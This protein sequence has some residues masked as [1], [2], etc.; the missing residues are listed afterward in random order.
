MSLL[1]R[2]GFGQNR[3]QE[4]IRAEQVTALQAAL[5]K[6]RDVALRG[7]RMQRGLA[8][9]VGAVMLALGFVLGTYR[10]PLKQSSVD[11]LSPLGLAQSPRDVD[12]A[13]AAFDKGS[14]EKALQIV[15]PLA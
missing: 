2:L 1:Q 4:A 13:Y 7:K 10:E 9:F 3:T 12:A 11:L 8:V 5:N 14:Y 6:C 15:R